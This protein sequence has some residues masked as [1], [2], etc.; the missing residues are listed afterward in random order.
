MN[1]RFANPN[2]ALPSIGPDSFRSAMRELSGGVSVITVGIGN[3]RSG[4]TAT[5]VSALSL[6]PPTLIVC[7][8]KGSST[9]PLLMRYRSF[10]VNILHA[11]HEHV[12]ERFSGRNGAKGEQ[13]YGEDHW[14]ILGTGASLLADALAALDCELEEAID[15]HSHGIVIG[16]VKAIH[17]GV[18]AETLV[19]WRGRYGGFRCLRS[20]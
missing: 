11:G 19:Y 2:S 14:I 12:A 4:M 16:R 13:R 20:L 6:D 15:R 9:W 3:D 8:N 1:I 10:G 18:T 17:I 7:V 5:S